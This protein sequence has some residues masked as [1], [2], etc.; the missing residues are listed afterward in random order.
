MIFNFA[1]VPYFS[2]AALLYACAASI[3]VEKLPR[4]FVPIY[5]LQG[6]DISRATPLYLEVLFAL[7]LLFIVFS[8]IVHILK[9]HFLLSKPSPF[10]WSVTLSVGVFIKNLCID[11]LVLFGLLPK[12]LTAY[13]P[14]KYHLKLF[15]KLKSLSSTKANLPVPYLPVN[16]IFFIKILY[17]NM[18]HNTN[19]QYLTG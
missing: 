2:I 4:L 14:L 17:K 12:L 8:E 19:L 5:A 15:T 6:L 18:L 9:L 11:I 3:S 10:M 7:F 1:K 16:F 13:E